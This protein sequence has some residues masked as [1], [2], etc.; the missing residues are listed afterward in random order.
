MKIM[1]EIRKGVYHRITKGWYETDASTPGYLLC[2][3]LVSP[4]Y[5]SFEYALSFHGLIPERVMVYTCATTL[6]NHTKD[7]VNAFGRFRFRDVPADVFA[8]GVN[9]L[10]VGDYPYMIATPEKAICDLLSKRPAVQSVKALKELLFDDLRIDEERFASLNTSDLL[11][12]ADR[13][14]KRNLRFLRRYLEGRK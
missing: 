8:F 2:S 9:R 3:Y 13:Y 11:F 14:P 1:S 5:L 6:K 7:Y 10:S 4:T 12:L